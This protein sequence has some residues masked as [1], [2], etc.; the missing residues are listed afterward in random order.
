MWWG[1]DERGPGRDDN[2]R[3]SPPPGAAAKRRRVEGCDS[4]KYLRPAV[5]TVSVVGGGAVHG[6]SVVGMVFETIAMDAGV[7]VIP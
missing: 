1:R 6:G 7:G 5:A 3:L 2:T 4:C